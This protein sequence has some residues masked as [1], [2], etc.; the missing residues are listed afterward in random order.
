MLKVVPTKVEARQDFELSLDEI[1]REGARRLLVQA[2]HQEVEEYIQQHSKETDD[3]GRRLVV[4]NGV[5]KARTITVGSGSIEVKA[6]RV[7]DRRDGQNFLSSILPPYL[8]KSPKVESLLPLLYLKGLST[9]DFKSALGEFLGEGTLGLSPA[10]IVNLKKMW[11]QEFDT[12]S[13]RPI[14]KKYVYIWADGMNMQVRLGEDKKVCLLVIIGATEDGNKELLAVHPGYRES[15]DSWNT[16]LRSLTD[17]GMTAP[18][19]AIGDGALGFWA[20]IRT[21]NGFEDT[22]EQRCWVHKIANVLDKLPKRLQS[23]AKNLLHEM[24]KAEKES[25]ALKARERFEKLY[26]EKYPKASECLTKSWT[27][28]TAFF[29]YPALHWQHIRT[30]NPIESSFATVKLRTKVTKGAGSKETAAVMAFK[31]LHECQRKWRKLRGHAEIKNLLKGV[32]Y[33]DGVMI[34]PSAHHEVAAS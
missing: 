24:M 5:G 7:D 8:R 11:E 21:A 9:N 16:V 1:A 29:K 20:A 34:T 32:E 19:L 31:L 23:D 33:E 17:R 6:P 4:R 15:K 18:M 26:S 27:E 22:E 2:L 28:L 10:S 30:T 14:T 25:D 12:W 3:D 13:K